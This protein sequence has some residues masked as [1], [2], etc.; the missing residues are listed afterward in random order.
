MAF[1]LGGAAG[2]GPQARQ[3]NELEEIET[4]GVQF[5]SIAAHDKS[6]GT[7][8]IKLLPQPWPSD[9]LPPSY[10]NLLAVASRKGILAAAGPDSLVVT[11]TEKLRQKLGDKNA[12]KQGEW[13]A[14]QPDLTIPMPRLSQ[15]AFT[16]DE[17][18]LVVSAE[19]GGGLAVHDVGALMQGNKDSK[20]QIGTQ[21]VATRCLCPNPMPELAENVAV[22]LTGGQLMIANLKEQRF[23]DGQHAAVL[24]DGA[25]CVAWSN[26]GKQLTAGLQDGTAVQMKPDGSPQA[27]VPRPPGLEGEQYI[28]SISWLSN[29]EF[30]IGHTAPN[31][32]PDMVPDT[33]FHYIQ[34]EK[35]TQN[36][37]FHKLLEEP[38]MGFNTQRSPPQYFFSRLRGWKPNLDDLLMAA[39]T[40]GDKVGIITKSSKALSRDHPVVNAYTRATIGIDSCQADFPM[41]AIN[42]E[43]PDPPSTIGMSLDLSGTEKVYR[44]VAKSDLEWSPVPLPALFV[45]NYEGI[46]GAWWVVYADSVESETPFDG[47]TAAN[48]ALQSSQ[49]QAQPQQTAASSPWSN[50]ASSAPAFGQ[51]GFGSSAPKA[52]PFGQAAGS[53]FGSAPKPA[54]GQPSQPAFGQTSFGT[55]SKPAFGQPSFGSPS[56]S[57]PAFGQT[58]FGQLSM[59]GSTFGQSPSQPQQP[60]QPFGSGSAAK[61][62]PFSKFGQQ[63]GASPFASAG[64]TGQSPFGGLNKTSQPAFAGTGNGG[65]TFGQPSAPGSAFGKPAETSSFGKSPFGTTATQTSAFGQKAE[66]PKIQESEMGDVDDQPAAAADTAPKEEPKPFG[67]GMK[68]FKLE[69]SFKPD[70]TAKDDLPKPGE[71]S[72]SFGLGS[73]FGQAL[74]EAASKPAQPDTS[75]KFG[76]GFGKTP[77][78]TEQKPLFGNLGKSST[79]FGAPS[80]GLS[81][82]PKTAESPK[83]PPAESKAEDAPLPPDFTK[84]QEKAKPEVD[85]APL[86]PDFTRTPVEKEAPED[87][88]LPP[89]PQEQA[90]PVS[91]PDAPLPPDFTAKQKETKDNEE[92]LPPI[93]GSPPVEV[94][95]PESPEGDKEDLNDGPSFTKPKSPWGFGSVPYKTDAPESP[96]P[97]SP[98]K[99][100]DAPTPDFKAS[101]T[102]AGLP[103]T[104][105][106]VF[107]PPKKEPFRSPSPVRAASTSMLSPGPRRHQPITLPPPTPLTRQT[108][109]PPTEPE[110]DF[111][112][113]AEDDRQFEDTQARLS[114]SPQA[115][116]KLGE[117][118]VHQDYVG[119]PGSNSVAGSMEQLYRDIQDMVDTVGLNALELASFIK[120]H[121]TITHEGRTREDLDIDVD[122]EENDWVLAEIEDLA[123]VEDSLARN[124]ETGRVA[125]VRAK[126]SELVRLSKEVAQLRRRLIDVRK[127]LESRR[128]PEKQRQIRATPLSEEQ[129]AQQIALR[130]TFAE[131]QKLLSQAEEGIIVLRAK[132]AS[133]ATA[134]GANG[135]AS[136]STATPTA[137]AV[138]NT[139]RRMTAMVEA[140]S[141]DLDVIEAKMRKAKILGAF[142]DEDDYE[143]A[144]AE[145]PEDITAGI[146]AMTLRSSLGRHSRESSPAVWATPPSGMRRSIRGS[147]PGTGRS[148]RLLDWAS[149]SPLPAKLSIEGG[150][151]TGIGSGLVTKAEVKTFVRKSEKKKFVASRVKE[152]VAARGVKVTRF[153]GAQA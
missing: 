116:T 86:P 21:N 16:A 99:P 78:K 54:F 81:F 79:A 44:P 19:E 140:K 104:F 42:P 85:D 45:L 105:N 56:T 87:A 41:S 115:K 50:S 53:A 107:S 38:C 40:A 142:D 51:S 135:G 62:S 24:K 32:E 27:I 63:A 59:P 23:M 52:S 22:V 110:P 91:P 108:S 71:P 13:V 144:P 67:L 134:K 119:K 7:N 1:S 148:Q 150:D 130:N 26:K 90:T 141:G 6:A 94:E 3:G 10:A 147:T 69:S 77:E 30:L 113:W 95:I 64:Q 46:L 137:E 80:S 123:K 74:G 118:Y 58:S 131:T 126:I 138:E 103:K 100:A 43:M 11:S 153:S 109:H 117:L 89:D 96:K 75:S 18:Y 129:S 36:Y 88:P 49:T 15:V 48:G 57:K 133:A 143:P 111:G 55:P 29:D 33:T 145:D 152:A 76:F 92:D 97:R 37:V 31:S 65:S 82:P 124:L 25:T 132:L 114:S 61:E 84:P 12:E 151:G 127:N 149:G 73:S 146:T 34:R 28:S 136:S 122:G 106:P 93:A 35:G 83:S 17:Q 4:E 125:D 39:S 101:T 72:G 98:F 20:F 47:L 66:E 120:G 14:F 9:R 139:I 102:P 70:G 60:Q 68:G 2:A 5:K 128:D 8:K 121:N 112:E